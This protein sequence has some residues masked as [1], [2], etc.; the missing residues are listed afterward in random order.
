MCEA[1]FETFI[2]DN[3]FSSEGISNAIYELLFYN[4]D[5]LDDNQ[6]KRVDD[7]ITKIVSAVS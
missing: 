6:T 4:P 3:S 2:D 7:L 1:L 5:T